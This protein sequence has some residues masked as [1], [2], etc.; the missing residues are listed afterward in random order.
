M[1]Q[2]LILFI[3][4]SITLALLNVLFHLFASFF[5]KDYMSY[6]LSGESF[7]LSLLLVVF[8]SFFQ[9]F[10]FNKYTKGFLPPLCFALSFLLIICFDESGYGSEFVFITVSV[11]SKPIYL[12]SFIIEKIPF[13]YLRITVWSLTYSFGFGLYLFFNYCLVKCLIYPFLASLKKKAVG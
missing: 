6:D 12:L 10:F 7:L 8:F 9:C 4:L 2:K 1:K 5:V 13:N 11:F 3:E